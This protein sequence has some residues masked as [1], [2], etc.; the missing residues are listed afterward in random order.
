MDIEFALRH[1]RL[2]AAGVQ[3]RHIELGLAGQID[4]AGGNLQLRAGGGLGPERVAGTDRIVRGGR[5]PVRVGA[6]AK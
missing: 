3:C 2:E 6:G 1:D 4:A 5:A